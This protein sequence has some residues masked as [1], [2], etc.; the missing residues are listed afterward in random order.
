MK[1]NAVSEMIPLTWPENSNMH[2]FAPEDQTLGYQILIS[3]LADSL[4]LITELPGVSFQPN[5]GSQGEYAGLLVIRA[6]HQSRVTNT[7]K[8]F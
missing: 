6:Y 5:A 7:E 2:P 4:A 8:L 1:L 3:K